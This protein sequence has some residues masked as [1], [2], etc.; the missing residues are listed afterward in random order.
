MG[1]QYSKDTEIIHWVSRGE[2]LHK[3]AKRYLPLTEELTVGALVE[4][5]KLLSG[6]DGSLIRPEQRLL[7]PLV[8]SRPV[9]AKTVP[10]RI[11]FE[12]KGIY[13]NRYT[14]ATQKIQRMVEK[15]I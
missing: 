11:D 12:A 10:K 6:I 4:K 5:I 2:S 1:K 15:L 3:I 8:R 14:M 13:L 7:I 9:A